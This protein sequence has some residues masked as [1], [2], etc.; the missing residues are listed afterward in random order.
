LRLER[1]PV[2]IDPTATYTPI[3]IRSFGKGLFH[4]DE[5]PGDELSKLRF[6]AVRPG[7]LIISNIKGW[8]G[9]I[10]VSG[11]ADAACIASNR[12]LTYDADPL[13]ADVS[14]LRYFFLSQGG[15]PLIQ[16]ASPGSAD[17]NRTLAIDRFE[18]LEIPLPDIAEQ[19]RVAAKLDR[20]SSS[21]TEVSRLSS[22][23]KLR[24]N[25]LLGAL[26]ESETDATTAL[27]DVLVPHREE[28]RVDPDA[29]YRLV[30]VFSFGKGMFAKQPIL[31]IETKYRTLRRIREGQF[32]FAR[33]NAW[34]GGLAIVGRALDG[35]YVTQEFPVFTVDTRRAHPAYLA[36]LCQ[37]PRLWDALMQKARGVGARTG[38]RRLRVHP[39]HL[40]SVEVPLP[41]LEEQARIAAI[42]AKI[43]AV[44][45]RIETRERLASALVPSLLNR[46]FAGLQ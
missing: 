15:L 7:R 5:M 19:R 45:A 40:L 24:C 33:L 46:A 34:E 18:A 43:T 28:V 26:V 39:E 23:G 32:V 41:A 20:L 13:R 25:A 37:W 30:G 11:D 44:L 22:E 2:P 9:A 3:G 29:A 36:L 12:F 42:A 14:Y 38:A 21:M 10:A 6:F 31:G 8:E 27:G 16:R 1:L 17:R 4:Y 35:M